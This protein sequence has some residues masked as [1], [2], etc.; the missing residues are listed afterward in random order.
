MVKRFL[1]RPGLPT[2]RIVWDAAGLPADQA[3]AAW[4]NVLETVRAD[5]TVKDVTDGRLMVGAWPRDDWHA[6]L[7]GGERLHLRRGRKKSSP[8]CAVDLGKL[9]F[10]GAAPAL[11]SRAARPFSST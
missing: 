6:A 11:G 5:A 1:H 7:R 9:S 3:D 2:P 10:P 4:R 8:I